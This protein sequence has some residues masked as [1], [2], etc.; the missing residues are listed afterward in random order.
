M[1]PALPDGLLSDL[2]RKTLT[3]IEGVQRAGLNS[4]SDLRFFQSRKS[5]AHLRKEGRGERHQEIRVFRIQGHK[6]NP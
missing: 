3:G 6:T 5:R 1:N 4:H 2:N